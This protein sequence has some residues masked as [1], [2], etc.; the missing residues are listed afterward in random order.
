MRKYIKLDIA[1]NCVCYWFI[2]FVITLKQALN[3]LNVKPLISQFLQAYHQLLHLK[4]VNW[5][6][7]NTITSR[8]ISRSIDDL[9]RVYKLIRLSVPFHARIS[10]SVENAENRKHLPL[11]V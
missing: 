7:G 1:I 2:F 11:M 3:E 6:M 4:N 9:Y 10:R 5:T 8:S